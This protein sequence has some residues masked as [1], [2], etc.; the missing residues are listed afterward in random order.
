MQPISFYTL[1]KKLRSADG[2]LVDGHLAK[3]SCKKKN[4]IEIIALNDH[5]KS[6]FKI[7]ENANIILIEEHNEIQVFDC[8]EQRVKNHAVELCRYRDKDPIRIQILKIADLG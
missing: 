6:I 7:T 1:S 4:E 3:A 5:E 2:V 8:E